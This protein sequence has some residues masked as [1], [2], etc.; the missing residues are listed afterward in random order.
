M[1]FRNDLVTLRRLAARRSLSAGQALR[2]GQVQGAELQGWRDAGA[3]LDEKG[4]VARVG[5]YGLPPNLGA[6][7]HLDIP[8][9]A[10][11]FAAACKTVV[12][13]PMRAVIFSW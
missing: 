4:I 10:R 6:W 5:P 11:W 12:R 13:F 8:V 3:A 1:P 7:S 9:Q 2:H